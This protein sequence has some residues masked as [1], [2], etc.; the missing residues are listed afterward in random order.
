[1]LV[2]PFPIVLLLALIQFPEIVVI[3]MM[4]FFVLSERSPFVIVPLVVIAVLRIVVPLGVV[5]VTVVIS[6][7]VLRV[8]LERHCQEC[9]NHYQS[10]LSFHSCF[11]PRQ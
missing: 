8:N 10:N 4:A 9:S 7:V 11:S 6:V 2:S 1:V 3:A 5:I